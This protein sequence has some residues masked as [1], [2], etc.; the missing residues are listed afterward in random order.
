MRISLVQKEAFLAVIR[1]LKLQGHWRLFLFGSRAND[2]RRGSDIDLLLLVHQSDKYLAQ[3]L[4]SHCIA[5]MKKRTSDE[6]IDLLIKFH[7]EI[8]T[9]EFL[10]TIKNQLIELI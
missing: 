6:K 2:E 8:A 9:D 10:A 4:R 1:E 7:D 5:Q 3:S